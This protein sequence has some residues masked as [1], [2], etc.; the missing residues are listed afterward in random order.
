MNKV[1]RISLAF[2]A[3]WLVAFPGW[4]QT[5]A[6]AAEK[7]RRAS[8]LIQA[9]NPEAAIPI[10]RE[11]A[12][13][14]PAEPAFRVNLAIADFKTGRYRE[15]IA[16]CTL[17]LKTQPD[18]FPAWLFLGASHL[19]LSET[20]EAAEAL[21]KALALQP[22]DVNARL[23][24]GDALLAREQYAEAVEDYAVASAVM[25][26]SPRVWLGLGK[27]YE[28]LT[29]AS[30]GRLQTTAPGSAELFA[31]NADLA[32]VR[33]QLAP[34]FQNYRQALRVRREFRG[35]HT[36][37]AEIYQLAGHPDWAEAERALEPQAPA[38]CMS[39]PLECQFA[40]RRLQEVATAQPQTPSEMYWQAKAFHALSR[41][42]YARLEEL[43]PSREQYEAAAAAHEKSGQ[44]REAAE[45]WKR[46]L[47]LA[48]GDMEIE[49]RMALAYCH[50]ND[51]YSALPLIDGLLKQQPSSA[52]MNYLYGL[53]LSD[54]RD[55][56]RALPYL[57]S[58][59]RLDA[60]FLPARAAL[61]EA[62]LETGDP[63]RAIPHL[64]AAASQDEDGRR[65][66][67]LARAYRVS[68]KREQA[69]ATLQEYR[70]IQ[71]RREAADKSEPRITAPDPVSP[72]REP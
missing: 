45:A 39:Q 4:G 7:S 41:Q 11:L 14:F 72:A 42:A 30:L 2:G 64:E 26:D 66:Y 15:T 65:H 21:R 60:S 25:P 70:G 40:A 46:A 58:A 24:L 63:E 67:Q 5:P 61:G 71:E 55:F 53:A 37:I 47:G 3:T 19:K 50:S 23:M 51:C 17:L 36:A 31:L 12:K 38:D 9:G 48:P 62:Y 18:L 10:Y 56:A 6:E 33:G 34:A 28:G 57:E 13:A 54:T 29:A 22:G 1:I 32:F 49:R 52:E 69:A 8:A 20:G 44:Y 68:G 59:V 16:E 43:P 35:A 27:A